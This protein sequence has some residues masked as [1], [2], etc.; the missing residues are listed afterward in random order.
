[1]YRL[2]NPFENQMAA[3]QFVSNKKDQAVIFN[4]LIDNRYDLNSLLANTK[5]KG[6]DAAK[7]YKIKEINIYPGTKSSINEETV[8]SGEYLMTIGIN[9]N[10]SHR[11]TSV[12]IEINEAK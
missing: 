10:L 1:M 12:V 9:P 7:K 5:L 3:V 8:Y 2:V 11:R 4:Y 6:L